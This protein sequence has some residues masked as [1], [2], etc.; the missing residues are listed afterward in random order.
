MKINYIV[1]LLLL[2]VIIAPLCFIACKKDSAP[3]NDGM[4]QLLSFGPT[5]ANPGD[6]IRFF[7]N[8]LEKVTEI[9]FENAKVASNKFVRQSST[10][11]YVVVPVETEK[12]YVTLKSSTGDVKSKTEFNIGIATTVTSITSTARP[13][14]NV[15]IKGNYLNWVTAVTFTDGKVATQFVS[16]S[17]NELVVKV[18]D[19][20]QTGTLVLAYGGTDSSFVETKD[21]LHVTLPMA[22][23]FAP[24]P[25]KHQSNVTIKGTDLDLTKKVYFN[26]VPNA[27]TN[28]VS[29][30]ATELVVK[31]PDSTETGKVMLEAASGV[32]STSQVDLQIILPVVTALAPN[33]I[34]HQTNLTITGTNL[35]LTKKVYFTGAPDAI[36]TFVSQSATQLVVKVPA[37]AQ[38]GK[39]TLEAGS[40][41]SSSS[42]DLKLV[43]PV[44]TSLSPNPIDPETDLTITGTNL[45]LVTAVAIQNADPV[46]TFVSQTA[47]QIVLKVPKGVAEGK[48]TMSVLNST[49]TVLSNDVLKINGAV[50]PPVVAF[51]FYSDAVTSN[52]NGWTGGGW[53]GTANYGNTNPVRVGDKSVRIDYSG[54]Y[55]APMQLGGASVTIAPYTTF[56]I[57]LYGGPGS[58]GLKVNIGINNKDSYTINLVEG[59][60][61]DYQIPISQLTTDAVITDLILK[62][63]NGSGGFTVYVDA[64]GLN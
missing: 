11:I 4:T 64:M 43:W 63:Y 33:P 25:I 23:G 17:L 39:I 54:G 51:P 15:T 53:G 28:F 27:I 24:N 7:G 35:D 32:K 60:W 40:V 47:T 59:K 14:E 12:G 49:V 22:T 62:E 58:N 1:R 42:M 16:Q 48:V 37:G 36:T 34:K 2:T 10:E 55:G 26:G 8:N 9:D 57:S 41:K 6:T 5:G 13:G 30:T 3:A 46:K 52:W 44:A 50:P 45:D 56:K 38:D 31:V 18:P 19:D 21:T 29:K 61:T 20:A